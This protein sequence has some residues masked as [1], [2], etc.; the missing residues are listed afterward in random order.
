MGKTHAWS[1]QHSVDDRERVSSGARMSFSDRKKCTP[2]STR[3]VRFQL[4]LF[5]R[6]RS[7][8]RRLL[9]FCGPLDGKPSVADLEDDPLA[10]Y[11]VSC[12]PIVTMT[13]MYAVCQARLPRA[14]FV[15]GV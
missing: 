15:P 4:L 2:D 12:E 9:N 10:D 3:T 11:I 6:N 5:D 8:R 1:R 14:F 13:V 7:G